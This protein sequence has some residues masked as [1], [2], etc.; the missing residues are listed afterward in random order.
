MK[1]KLKNKVL[2]NQIKKFVY[3]GATRDLVKEAF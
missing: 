1:W 3:A 2:E